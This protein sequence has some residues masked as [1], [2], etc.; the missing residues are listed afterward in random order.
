M[1]VVNPKSISGINS[2]TMASGGDDLLTIHSNNTTE[3]VRVNNSGDVI[4]GSGVTLS[5]DGDAFFTGVCTATSFSGDGS[6]LTGISAGTALSGSTDNT[7]TTVT[8]ANAITG[9]A[10]LKFDGGGTLTIV[11][12]ELAEASD[13]FSINIQSGNND[14]YVKSGGTI[15][16]AFKGS[17]K[18][19]QLTSGN[20]VI[21]TSGKG[22]DFSADGNASGSSSEVLDDY[23]EGTFTPTM[24]NSVT[25]HSGNDL[26]SYVKVGH[27]VHVTG[28]LRINSDNS[29]SVFSI[30]NMP[31]ATVNASDQAGN[32]IGA[33]SLYD[34][35]MNSGYSQ[36]ISVMNPN[37][38]TLNVQNLKQSGNQ[39][40]G[41]TL[42]AN[43][44][45]G[46]SICYR[47]A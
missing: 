34:Q 21:G 16:A 15:F 2:I 4:V 43:A 31:F 30:T 20:L 37:S 18:D 35:D 13:N 36:V 44:Y 11:D 33:V 29:N 14:F 7:V 5:P 27:L 26:L 46:I 38:T 40:P 3:R 24:A 10:N 47:A 9:E 42:I 1:T 22:I 12:T 45:I 25:L 6:N 23:E 41:L 39:A 19:L 17:A 8:G 28:V 32:A